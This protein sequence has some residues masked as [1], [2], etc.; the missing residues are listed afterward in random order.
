[1]AHSDSLAKDPIGDSVTQRHIGGALQ[2]QTD[3]PGDARLQRRLKVLSLSCL[4]PNSQ[5]PGQGLFVQARVRAMN[6]AADVMVVQPVELPDYSQ[7]PGSWFEGRSLPRRSQDGGLD[8]WR[9]RWW[10][11]PGAGASNSIYLAA[12]VLPLVR[13]LHRQRQFDIIDAH[14]GQPTGVAA[15]I[16]SA[17]LRIPFAVTIRGSEV[18]HARYPARKRFMAWSFR[19]AARVI[20]V[21]QRLREFALSL[22]ALPERT[23]V[24]PNGVD[25]SVFHPMDRAACR[26]KY[27]IAQNEKVIL[28]AGHL[29][30]LKGHHRIVRALTAIPQATLLIAGDADRAADFTGR[31]RQEISACGVESRVRLLGH[32]RQNELA[33]LMNAADL[34]CLA[35]SR[36]GWPNVVHEALS[37]GTPVVATDVGAIPEMLPSAELGQIVPPDNVEALTAALSQA[38]V[39]D[40]DRGR[41]S[42]WGESRSWETVGRE[43]IGQFADF[44]SAS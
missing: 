4:Y 6:T 31:I 39:K 21:S 20:A 23:V 34:F 10:H 19:R 24:I 18:V 29:F 9:P 5:L 11:P 43:V 7:Q 22:G 32:V 27:Q 25:R 33:E 37:C 17:A 1:M 13:K 14:F 26:D 30:E 38:I 44:V 2:G 36:E 42:T 28:S 35:S 41:I 15:A 12:G 40:W 16:L 8:V 3:M